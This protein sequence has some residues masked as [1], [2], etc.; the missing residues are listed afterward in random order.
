LCSISVAPLWQNP[1]FCRHL[2]LSVVGNFFFPFN[3]K[4]RHNYGRME[5][6][7]WI[8]SGRLI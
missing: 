8:G 2:C 1:N 6:S 7:I 5:E 3:K 4:I